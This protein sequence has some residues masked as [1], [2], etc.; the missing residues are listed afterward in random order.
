M[1]TKKLRKSVLERLEVLK[2]T[3]FFV[4]DRETLECPSREMLK[5]DILLKRSWPTQ[6]GLPLRNSPVKKKLKVTSVNYHQIFHK[7]LPLKRYIYMW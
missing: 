3:V 6:D 1:S 4:N 7:P 5:L 2:H